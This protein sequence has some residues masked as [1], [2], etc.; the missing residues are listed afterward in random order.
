MPHTPPETFDGTPVEGATADPHG[1][2]IF[3]LDLQVGR[4]VQK[5]KDE[6]LYENTLFIFTSDNGGLGGGI[7]TGTTHDSSNGLRGNKGNIYEGGHRVPFIATWPGRIA[8]NSI[9]TEPIMVQDL[10]ATLY[11]LTGQAQP[12]EAGLDSFNILPLLLSTPGAVGREQMMLQSGASSE[13]VAIRMGDWKLIIDTKKNNTDTRTSVELFDMAS[14]PEE[15]ESQN[16][17]N[18]PAQATRVAEMLAEYNRQRG[19]DKGTLLGNPLSRS[20]AA[21]NPSLLDTDGDGVSD[22]DEYT[23]GTDAFNSSALLKIERTDV[24]NDGGHR[25]GF[26]TVSERVYSAYYRTNLL[27]GGWSLLTNGIVGDSSAA[28][29]THRTFDSPC[30][31]RIGV[32]K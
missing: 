12:A 3:E 16:L 18:D 9:C 26:N 14:N 10:M 27:S 17:I 7:E 4:M 32:E 28:V 24:L 8:T 6:G 20:S 2:M 23:A 11:A 15:D 1:D 31:Y 21:V 25:F 30:F 22:A 19:S 29:I 13:Q 5:L